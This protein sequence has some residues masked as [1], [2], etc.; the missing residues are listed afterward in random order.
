MCRL[1]IQNLPK[2][3][4]CTAVLR[5]T[6]VHNITTDNCGNSLNKFNTE[7]TCNREQVQGNNNSTT[8]A[9][10]GCAWVRACHLRLGLAHVIVKVNEVV[11]Q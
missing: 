4:K 5:S 3:Y 9:K 6:F 10:Y 1:Y 2:H 7:T 8:S 11:S